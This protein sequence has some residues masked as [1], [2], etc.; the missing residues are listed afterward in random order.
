MERN[1]KNQRQLAHSV[2]YT[3]RNMLNEKHYENG[4][5]ESIKLLLEDMSQDMERLN[6]LRLI[7]GTW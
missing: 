4:S 2:M 5:T 6:D 3:L 1:M 7:N